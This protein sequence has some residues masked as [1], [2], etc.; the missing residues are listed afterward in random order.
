MPEKKRRDKECVKLQQELQDEQNAKDTIMG[1]VVPV[2]HET[3]PRNKGPKKPKMM[4]KYRPNVPPPWYASKDGPGVTF[5]GTPEE[6]TAVMIK[7]NMELAKLPKASLYDVEQVKYNVNEYLRLYSEY[8]LK[9]TIAGLAMALKVN[10]RRLAEIRTGELISGTKR[11]DYPEEVVEIVRWAYQ[12]NENMWES[13]M[14][15]QKIHPTSGIFLGVNNF[16]YRNTSEVQV[17]AGRPADELYSAEEIKS[18]YQAIDQP[19]QLETTA[20]ESAESE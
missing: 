5:Q 14:L 9:P 15:T 6:L 4:S 12:M 13:Y 10:R 7:V 19:K 17:S 1:G 16:G 8:N 2:K 3:K 11:Q 20:K 18:R